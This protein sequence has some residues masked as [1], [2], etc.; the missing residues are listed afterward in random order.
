MKG[1]E[2]ADI[3]A[4]KVIVGRRELDGT[5][6]R[7]AEMKNQKKYKGAHQRT[8]RMARRDG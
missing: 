2:Q 6:R 3:G 5:M 1:K 4:R 7:K 8:K